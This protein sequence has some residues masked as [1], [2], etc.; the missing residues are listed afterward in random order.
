MSI[1]VPKV[2]EFL[3]GDNLALSLALRMLTKGFMMQYQE[4]LRHKQI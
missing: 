4:G 3:P 1:P 2:K